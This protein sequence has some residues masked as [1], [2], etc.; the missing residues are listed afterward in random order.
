MS[1]YKEALTQ[2]MTDLSSDPRACFCGYGLLAGQQN[3]TLKGVAREQIVECPVAENLM[4]GV[5]IGLSLKGRLPLVLYERADFTYNAMDAI[6]NHLNAMATLSRGE[7]NPAVILRVVVGNKTKPLFTG[8]VH[9]ANPA[10]A[11]RHLV[12]FPVIE[13]HD[14]LE[15]GREYWRA[16]DRQMDGRST[17]LVEFKDYY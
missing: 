16:C 8:P 7:F 1:S 12:D 6:V 15:I 9:T 14:P 4:T 17:M 3:G 5:A 13:L 10:E 2:A 11:F